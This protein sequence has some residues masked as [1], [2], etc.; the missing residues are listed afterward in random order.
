MSE[1]LFDLS[2]RPATAGKI[3][4]FCKHTLPSQ[5]VKVHL[6]AAHTQKK[7]KKEKKVQ[8]VHKKSDF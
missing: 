4:T 7:R 1:A 8:P 2:S 5:V 6:C 3:I